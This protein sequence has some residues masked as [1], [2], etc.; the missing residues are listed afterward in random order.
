M[1]TSLLTALPLC[2]ALVAC[3]NNSSST[4]KSNAV[5]VPNNLEFTK[6]AVGPRITKAQA[7]EIKSTFVTKPMMILPPGELVFPDK[8]MPAYEKEA[9]ERELARQDPN[10]YQL[11]KELR[12]GCAK[13]HPT[14]SFNATFPTDSVTAE[15]AFDVLQIGDMYSFNASAG[16]TGANCPV[17]LS[18]STALGADVISID[19]DDRSGSA[20]ASTGFK[21]NAVMKNPKYAGLLGTRGVI[22]DTNLSGLAIR[23]EVAKGFRDSALVTFNLAG[24]YLSLAADIPYSTEVRVLIKSNGE[25]QSTS[26]IVT[27]TQLTF[28]NFSASLEAHIN[29]ENETIVNEEYYLNGH[30]M[31]K[32][33]LQEL[34]GDNTPNSLSQTKQVREMLLN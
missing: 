29:T 31:T 8:D 4:P 24:T 22:V 27:K 2:F 23:R 7:S 30:S 3:T 34:F 9:K 16:L 20:T 6:P 26:E 14:M 21:L 11:L 32:Q 13:G 18:G 25:K 1:K 19:R 5:I 12:A 10:S 33:D 17:S 15:N 28:P